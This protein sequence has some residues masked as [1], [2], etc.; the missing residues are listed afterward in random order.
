MPNENLTRAKNAKADEFYTLSEDIKR[1]VVYYTTSLVGKRIYCPCDNPKYSNFY[2][3][4]KD[5][6]HTLKLK[7][8]QATYYKP[9][10]TPLDAFS[11]PQIAPPTLTTY[12]G[13]N[14]LI[15][16]L[17]RQSETFALRSV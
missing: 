9:D 4:F 1:E 11:D 12:D 5:N 8:L 16:P 14:E 7:S 15:E 2:K 6:F 3:F 13:E 10:Y 17:I